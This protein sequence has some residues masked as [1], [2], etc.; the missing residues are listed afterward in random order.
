MSKI[1]FFI[2][3]IFLLS[4]CSLPV[5]QIGDMPSD[6]RISAMKPGKH[7]KEDVTRL[8]GS[9]AH[10]TL[11]QEESWVYVESKEQQRAFLSPEETS[12]RVLVITFKPD[13][14]IAKISRLDLNDGVNVPYDS[15]VTKSYGKDLSVWDE[16][17][18]N[19]GRFPA[20]GQQ[21]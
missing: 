11:F 16:M 17:I 10:I 2:L 20:K 21:R 3:S 13:D 4:A 14:T 8:I 9:P 15:D 18:G 19:F 6:K 7:T 1:S 12:R 5:N